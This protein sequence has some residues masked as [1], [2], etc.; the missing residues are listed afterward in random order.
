MLDITPGPGPTPTPSSISLTADKSILSY[1]DSESATLSATVL[2]QSSQPMSGV[3]VEFFNGSTSMG[4][5]DTNSSGVATKSYSSTGAGDISLT[6]EAGTFVSETYSIEDCY[7]YGINTDAFTIPS[8]TTFSSNGEYI[9]ATT[10][11]SGEKV[12]YLNHTLSN[13]DNWV[14]ETE[15]AQLGTVQHMAVVWNDNTFYGGAVKNYST[16]YYAEMN[17]DTTKQIPNVVGDVYRVV[18]ENGVTTVTVNDNQIVSKT[19]S[20]K[21][22]FKVGY[23]INQG[24]TQYYKNIKLKPL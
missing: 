4:T 9:T 6:A 13:S 10:S 2:D 23:F 1:A 14:F 22:S 8:S 12:V 18:R 11:T 19:I 24:R 17:G 21:S 15:L 3:T 5:A 20:H 7:F 16:A